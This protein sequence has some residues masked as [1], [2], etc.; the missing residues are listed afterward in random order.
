MLYKAGLCALCALGCVAAW[1][2]AGAQDVYRCNGRTPLYSQAPCEGRIVD[3]REAPVRAR[4]NP[5]EQ[6]LRR[7]EQNH[8]LAQGLRQRPGETALQFDVRQRRA[9]MLPEDREECERLAKRIPV[10]QARMSSPDPE[11]VQDAQAALEQSRKRYA[12]MRC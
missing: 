4:P 1:S 6:D 12:G 2:P 7:I 10:E 5:R 9:R 8:I 3:T 11:V